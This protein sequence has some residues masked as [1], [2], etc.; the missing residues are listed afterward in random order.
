[1][2]MRGRLLG[3]LGVLLTCVRRA[4]TWTEKADAWTEER[5]SRRLVIPLQH[6]ETLSSPA[7]L[8]QTLV[9]QGP[10][11]HQ[12]KL[13][14]QDAM[15]FFAVL[16]PPRTPGSQAHCVLARQE[17]EIGT[18]P[19]RF[20]VVPDTGS[21]ML[22]VPDR[23]CKS[24]PCLEHKR[25]SLH[26]SS[27][28]VVLPSPRAPGYAIS[29]DI[30]YG[31]GAMRGVLVADKVV[32][33]GETVPRMTLLAATDVED[34]NMPADGILGLG[35]GRELAA[36]SNLM[37]ELT[38]SHK[39]PNMVSF[40]LPVERNRGALVLGEPDPELYLG[41][42]H[43]HP[44]IRAAKGD[45]F[46]ALNLSWLSVG[47]KGENMCPDTCVALID[48]GTSLIIAPSSIAQVYCGLRA[49][50]CCL[51]HDPDPPLALTY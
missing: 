43:W 35:R 47:D 24:K 38:K 29:A 10:S 26:D 28:G 48:T 21:Y 31:T 15:S 33:A 25:L 36:H 14:N 4:D 44:V 41:P 8:R 49:S 3:L 46:W 39:L 9:D 5:A 12:A 20:T 2:K 23:M 51:I 6:S 32:L 19:Q 37:T 1:M 16:Q 7:G 22:W 45:N 40:Y 50:I 30:V 11:P 18:P 34:M 42:L 17:L 27:T 13:M